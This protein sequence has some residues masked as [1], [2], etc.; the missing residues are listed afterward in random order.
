MRTSYTG[1][2]FHIG[3]VPGSNL[4]YKIGC[5]TFPQLIHRLISSTPIIP[6]FDVKNPELM[7]ASSNKGEVHPRTGHGSP[8]REQRYSCTL[9]S[10]SALD[11]GGWA[12]LRPGRFTP[13]KDPVPIVQEAAW[14][15]GPV[16][17]GAENLA[18]TGIRSPYGAAFSE[19]VYRLSYRGPCVVK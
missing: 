15:T 11:G 10:T 6:P 9:S 1:P 13:G 7:T 5:P 14:A 2:V 17:T 19:L 3:E 8:G 16:W 18:P 4:G 12:T